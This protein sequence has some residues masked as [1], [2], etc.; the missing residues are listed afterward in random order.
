MSVHIISGNHTGL[1]IS[2][3]FIE[4]DRSVILYIHIQINQLISE[5]TF[6][7]AK[8]SPA[9][10]SALIPRGHRQ[11]QQTNSPRFPVKLRST[12]SG[13]LILR[14]GGKLPYTAVGKHAHIVH[15]RPGI[16]PKYFPVQCQR[17]PEI[18]QGRL[19]DRITHVKILS[20]TTVEIRTKL[21]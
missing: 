13:E 8:E 12:E 6:D 2:G 1:F 9:N 16:S 17:R 10:P 7:C 4:T 3:L 11:G 19:S 5:S 14:F 20:C 15:H 21:L 18:T